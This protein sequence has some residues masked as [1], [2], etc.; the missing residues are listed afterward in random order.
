MISKPTKPRASRSLRSPHVLATLVVVVAGALTHAE[1]RPAPRWLLLGPGLSDGARVELE[2]LA[3]RSGG[4]VQ[5]VR[6]DG[7][8][9]LR[10]SGKSDPLGDWAR[11]HGVPVSQDEPRAS[12][13]RPEA[14][15]AGHE[16][17]R[18]VLD[19]EPAALQGPVDVASVHTP[20]VR[21]PTLRPR[22]LDIPSC[23]LVP[24]APPCA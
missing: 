6:R 10:V 18:T 3:A 12:I 9:A 21:T 22:R 19:A 14:I 17:H 23:L 16:T 7:R 8:L 11:R 20:A 2:V 1:R 5:L 4:R 15:F 24:R 13:S